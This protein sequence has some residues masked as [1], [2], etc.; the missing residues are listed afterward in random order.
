LTLRGRGRGR[1][2]R[3]R[4]GPPGSSFISPI[5][6]RDQAIRNT[7]NNAAASRLS[8]VS[9]GY[10]D[11]P[12]AQFFADGQTRKQPLINRGTYTRT[13]AID[14]LVDV[15]LG[16]AG[17]AVPSPQ[18]RQIISLGAGTDTRYLRLRAQNKHH[19]LIY[20]EFDFP[21]ICE[22]K[23]RIVENILV[24]H[25]KEELKVNE[26]RYYCHPLDLRQ[27]PLK[28]IEDFKELRTD[29]P[30][31]IISECC[32][33]Y[34]QD[35]MANQVVNWVT[36]KLVSSMIIL[37]EPIGADD[38]FGQR[39]VQNLEAQGI[40]MPTIQKY[41]TLEDQKA[42]LEGLGFAS[43]KADNTETIW[44]TWIPETE[45]ERV[46]SLEGLDEVEEWQLLARHY[47]VVWGNTEKQPT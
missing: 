38:A 1:G 10:L 22:T 28:S 19:N 16:S 23:V 20:H 39:M 25:F 34:L 14:S 43:P 12:F 15:F 17:T 6:R 2:G 41:R 32:L 27:L 31:L 26:N 5:S 3:G 24:S 9:L 35:D 47:A 45:R 7:D 37:Y 46:N 4:G 42:R 33:C 30:T 40:V 18:P 8:A 29:I 44:E 11:D 21:D 13:M 36:S